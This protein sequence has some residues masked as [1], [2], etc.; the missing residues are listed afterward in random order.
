MSKI[1]II[2]DDDFL[3]SLA[4]GKLEKSGYQ[5]LMAPNGKL[6]IEEVKKGS[7]DLVVLDLM[8][9]EMSGFEVLEALRGDATTSTT[10]VIV[11]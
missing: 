1:L 10:R 11:F 5:V 6:G 8:L 9:P 2:E 4:V 7:P 3:R